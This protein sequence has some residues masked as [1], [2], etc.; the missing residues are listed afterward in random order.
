MLLSLDNI[1]T[2]QPQMIPADVKAKVITKEKLV[3]ILTR[4][5]TV[6]GPV[7]NGLLSNGETNH[8][9]D[10]VKL[11][12]CRLGAGNGL[13][14]AHVDVVGGQVAHVHGT[15]AALNTGPLDKVTDGK[16]IVRVGSFGGEVKAAVPAWLIFG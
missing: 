14:H 13:L 11:K 8:G 6:C 16:M 7:G 10:L 5:H 2:A 3:N 15:T 1:V 12:V 4:R 9:R